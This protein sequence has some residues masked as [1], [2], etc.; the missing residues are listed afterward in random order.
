MNNLQGQ[1]R[2]LIINTAE[3]YLY[4]SRVGKIVMLYGTI[5]KD[6]EKAVSTA[7]SMFFP[8]ILVQT[9][10]ESQPLSMNNFVGGL[11]SIDSNGKIT[12]SGITR[13]IEVCMM[14]E[15]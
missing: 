9:N 5:S 10:I 15:A 6:A 7:Y 14:Y 4:A 8:K 1:S 3:V 2:T 12:T 11:L 13:K